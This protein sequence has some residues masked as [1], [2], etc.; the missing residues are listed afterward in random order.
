MNNE[1]LFENAIRAYKNLKRLAKN[2]KSD[3]SF[4]AIFETLREG[5]EYYREASANAE[6]KYELEVKHIENLIRS[7]DMDNCEN[8]E[9]FN[10]AEK[11]KEEEREKWD[12]F[13]AKYK[14]INLLIHPSDVA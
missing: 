14:E 9:L 3:I 11:F 5:E 10:N 4:P 12:N 7:V 8:V 2:P 13:Y 1:E 6:R